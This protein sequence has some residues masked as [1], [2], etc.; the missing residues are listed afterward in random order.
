MSDFNIPNGE[1]MAQ[2]WDDVRHRFGS[3]IMM[4]ISLSN[5][6]QNVGINW[7]NNAKDDTP[8]V[9]LSLTV[10]E[11]L[12]MP[13]IAGNPHKL[14]TLIDILN[15][16]LAFDDPFGDMVDE[17]QSSGDSAEEILLNLEKLEIP[18]T[19]P[20]ELTRISK[21]TKKL[22]RAEE[23][24]TIGEFI[25]F[26]QK[27]A[28]NIVIGGDIRNFLNTFAERDEDGIAKYLPF[29]KGSKG[30]H[31]AEAI[32]VMVD[33]LSPGDRLAILENFGGDLS[34][35][36]KAK[37]KEMDEDDVLR[38]ESKIRNDLNVIMKWFS[39]QKLVLETRILT[40]ESLE[41]FFIPLNDPDKERVATGCARVYFKDIKPIKAKRGIFAWIASLFGR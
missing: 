36:D 9:Y 7:Y 10:D 13:S 16:T 31:L 1:A 39:D 15:E 4:D 37:T 20:L 40:G 14:K 5:L 8:G 18:E 25:R 21:E 2:E 30:L 11:A 22:C 26:S 24:L 3:S 23:L 32:G 12:M 35:K 38:L 6:G 28:Q 34:K 29:R 17:V 33:S 41:R 19:F 27:M